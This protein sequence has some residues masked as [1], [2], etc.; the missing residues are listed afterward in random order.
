MI[1]L[2]ESSKMFWLQVDL[3]QLRFLYLATEEGP[4]GRA[5]CL[6]T[7][8]C[9]VASQTKTFLQ[10]HSIAPS[11]L[12]PSVW[13]MLENSKCDGTLAK[14]KSLLISSSTAVWQERRL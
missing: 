11:G 13:K 12:F 8:E 2:F 7:F 14:A 10:Q 3:L 1:N 5:K 4:L 6:A 9:L